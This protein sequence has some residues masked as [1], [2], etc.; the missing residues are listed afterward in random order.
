MNLVLK[1]LKPGDE[2][3][4]FDMVKVFNEEFEA[5]DPNY[6]NKE[7]IKKLLPNKDFICLV[8]LIDNKVVGGLTGYNL[9][10]YSQNGSAMYVYDVAVHKSVQR[11]GIGTQLF[12]YLIEFCKIHKIPE[13]FV[14]ADAEDLHAVE[15]YKKLGGESLKFYQFDFDLSEDKQ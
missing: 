7:N 14:Q 6:V 9:Y 11:K 12:N 3:L 8:A 15:F 2:L 1:I 4:F 13:L 5:E 10:S